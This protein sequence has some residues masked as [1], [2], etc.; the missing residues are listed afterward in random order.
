MTATLMRERVHAALCSVRDPELDEA[1]TEL[2]FVRSIDVD[3]TSVA[4]E[5]RLPTYFCAPNFAYLMVADAHDAAS[6][7]P[8]VASVRVTLVDHFASDEINQGVA[9]SKGFAGSFPGQAVDELSKLRLTFL[10]KAHSAC[11]ERVA[12][13]L[14]RAGRVPED[15]ATVT[16][17]DAEPGS[18]AERLVRRRAELGLPS[19]PDAPL[20]VHDD[21]EPIEDEDIPGRLQFARTTRISIEGNAGLCRGLLAVRYGEGADSG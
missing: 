8:G 9:A 18:D 11:Q 12:A 1:I 16:L 14:I 5:L 10:R 2:G 17:A 4:I 19:G 15:L 20:L 7:V 6:T 3:G 21:G 13:A